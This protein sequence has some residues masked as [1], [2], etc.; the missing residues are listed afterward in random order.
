MLRDLSTSITNLAAAEGLRQETADTLLRKKY[1]ASEG[2]LWRWASGGARRKPDED[3][4]DEGKP[5][6][7]RRDEGM[8]RM[9]KAVREAVLWFLRR[10]LEG[11]VEVQRGMVERRIERVREKEKSV[12]YKSAA[13]GAAAGVPASAP[14]NI[15][16]SAEKKPPQQSAAGQ[17]ETNVT[18]SATLSESEVAA[19]E[20]QLSP[21]QLQLFAEENDSML[22]HYEDT[23]HKVQYV[24][25][26]LT[27]CLKYYAD[28]IETPKNHSWKSPPY[29][30]PSSATSPRKKTTSAS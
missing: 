26:T 17:I 23:L 12:L 9:T 20:A 7:Q 11:A 22:R 3:D 15:S 29:N 4:D 6:E 19:I 21:Q 18:D 25:L 13:A 8:A 2:F 30:R 14:A 27:L 28:E 5:A 16:V 10:G 24:F 1:G